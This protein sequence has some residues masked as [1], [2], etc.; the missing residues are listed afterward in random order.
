VVYFLVFGIGI[1]LVNAVV[2]VAV[3][4]AAQPIKAR[5][6]TNYKQGSR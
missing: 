5:E 6:I 1:A 3:A 2:A 4:T